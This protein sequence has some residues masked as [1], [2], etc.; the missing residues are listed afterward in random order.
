MDQEAHYRLLAERCVAEGRGRLERQHALVAGL[1]PDS[2]ILPLAKKVLSSMQ[3]AQHVRERHL[4]I[5]IHWRCFSSLNS[6]REF[7]GVSPIIPDLETRILPGYYP[8]ELVRKPD[9]KSDEPV[10]RCCRPATSVSGRHWVACQPPTPISAQTAR[11]SNSS[12]A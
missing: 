11:T 12:K 2:T 7:L 10:R 8:D 6:R 4:D 3:K 9:G 1:R 5:L